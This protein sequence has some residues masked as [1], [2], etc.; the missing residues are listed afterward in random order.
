VSY[1]IPFNKPFI[2]GK[3]L[4]YI[5][6]SVLQCQTSG[7]GLYTK[8]AQQLMKGTFGAREIL[9]TTSCTAALD[10]AAI[11]A[12]VKD[13]DEV[14]LPSFTFASTANAFLLRGARPVFVD[15]RRDTLNIDETLIEA[16][17]TART[18]AIAPVH[19]AG[20]GCEMDVISQ[21]AQ[22]H[23]LM[24]IEDAAQ[25]VN[26]KYKGKYLGTI[27][28]VGAYSFH[29]TKNVICGEGG[30]IILNRPELVE[31][32][33]IVREKGTNRTRFFRG[34]VDKYTW[35]DI[36]SSLL[37]SDIL[38]A[39]LY[40]Q[41]EN[42]DVIT[43]KRQEIYGIY[44]ARLRPLA[45]R[46]LVTLPSIPPECESNYHIFYIVLNSLYERTKLIEYLKA[47]SI[48]TVFHYVPL[49][50]SPMGTAMGYRPGMLPVTE[51]ISERLL[52]L[53]M[54]YEMQHS[55]VELVVDEICKFFRASNSAL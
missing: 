42:M 15:C 41:L 27:G 28:D 43:R 5:S 54:Y 14:I 11:L 16:A 8:R 12:D 3:E 36:G 25:G 21:I 18:R 47:R 4:Y 32:A 53:P 9:L 45:N 17:I 24:I 19:Y 46:G 51:T 38:A 23:E 6:Q 35:V 10:L 39:F 26:A 13:G 2:V 22:R 1:R 29:E 37:P 44:E 33:E 50:T 55:E 30:A 40:A 7:D 52:R 49:H 48:L 31:R 20:V 34:E